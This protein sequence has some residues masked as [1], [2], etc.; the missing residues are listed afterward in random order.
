[1]RR[2]VK[3]KKWNRKEEKVLTSFEKWM[4]PFW[5]CVWKLHYYYRH[6]DKNMKTTV[7]PDI[8]KD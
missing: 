7:I 4:Y 2:S 5:Q 1:M 6:Q 8:N 3:L